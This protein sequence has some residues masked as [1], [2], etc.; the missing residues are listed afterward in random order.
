MVRQ[1]DDLRFILDAAD[2]YGA[3]LPGEYQRILK[4]RE[5]REL[6]EYRS[7]RLVLEARDQL[8]LE[9][10]NREGAI[11]LSSPNP[12]SLPR[13][14]AVSEMVVVASSKVR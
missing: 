5:L 2:V 12:E 11:R 10:W 14:H 4:E 7:R 3:V 9:P 1:E 13:L 6:G 8:G